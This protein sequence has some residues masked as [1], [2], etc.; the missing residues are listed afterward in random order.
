MIFPIDFDKKDL[1]NHWKDYI[2]GKAQITIDANCYENEVRYIIR[3]LLL[4]PV[5]WLYKHLK[6]A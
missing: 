6:T 3:K 5:H 1:F 2:K 4:E